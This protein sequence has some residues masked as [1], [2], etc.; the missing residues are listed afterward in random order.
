GNRWRFPVPWRPA[1]SVRDVLVWPRARV[2]TR[3]WLF[4]VLVGTLALVITAIPYLV[5]VVF[6]RGERQFM[7]I[8]SDVPDTAQYLAWMRAFAHSPGLLIANPLTPEPNHAAFFNLLW[9]ALGHC[10]RI[11]HAQSIVLYQYFRWAAGAGFLAVL[12]VTCGVFCGRG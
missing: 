5:G 8:A 10:A 6:A 2:A 7:G 1:M 9:Y 3:E 4:P 12:W 11:M